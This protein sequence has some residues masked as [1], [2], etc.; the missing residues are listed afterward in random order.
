MALMLRLVIGDRWHPVIEGDISEAL[1]DLKTVEGKLSVWHI[2]ENKSNLNDVLVALATTRNGTRDLEYVLFNEQL[3]TELDIQCEKSRGETLYEEVNI[4][5]HRDLLDLTE[6]KC[7]RLARALMEKGQFDILIKDWIL[8]YM[9]NAVHSGQI[10][11]HQLKEKTQ[12]QLKPL[13]QPHSI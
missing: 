1:L 11:F 12:K 7:E 3:L 4:N 13:L 9:A 2:E 6:T 5:W 8:R 10:P